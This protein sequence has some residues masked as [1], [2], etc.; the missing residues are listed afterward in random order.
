MADLT[1]YKGA[2]PSLNVR[3]E[4][5]YMRYYQDNVSTLNNLVRKNPNVEPKMVGVQGHLE[6][7]IRTRF[8]WTRL[9][10]DINLGLE[11]GK[12]NV[13]PRWSQVEKDDLAEEMEWADEKP[14]RVII[15]CSCPSQ[16]TSNIRKLTTRPWPPAACVDMALPRLASPR[17]SSRPRIISP[18]AADR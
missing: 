16:V 14:N 8:E 1:L 6:H 5:W 7:G 17:H 9:Q 11:K 2:A 10:E 15:V 4:L 12:I 3:G 18:S 13:R